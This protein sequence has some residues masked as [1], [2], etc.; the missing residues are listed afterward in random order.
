MRDLREF[1]QR[2]GPAEFAPYTSFRISLFFFRTANLFRKN[3]RIS[4]RENFHVES[5]L[6]QIFL[7][8]PT[9]E[10]RRSC[11]AFLYIR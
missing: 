11:V 8:R 3:S 1:P 9:R 7:Y 5:G 10:G 2:N 6:M 4:N